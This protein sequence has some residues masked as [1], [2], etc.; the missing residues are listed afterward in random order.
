M[1]NFN[2]L[3]VIPD[4]GISTDQT[5]RI[6]RATYGDGYEQRVAAGINT[7]PEEWSL[8]WNNRSANDANK[9]IKF[10]EDQKGA[11]AFDWYPPDSE[12]S[13]STTS[14]FD[15]KLIDTTQSFTNRLLGSTIATSGG[16]ATISAIDSGTALSLSSNLI[17]DSTSAGLDYS[18]YPTKKYKCEKWNTSIPLLGYRTISATFTKV[19][20]P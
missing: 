13:S 18:I 1:A 19:F 20:E 11:T 4:R 14:S 12:I 7:L 3:N 2:D 16:T 17:P 9:V 5:T 15:F 6:F 8:S 10:L